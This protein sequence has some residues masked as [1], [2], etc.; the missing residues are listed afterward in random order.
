MDEKELLK[1]I[2]EAARELLQS[3]R[4]FDIVRLHLCM[5]IFVAVHI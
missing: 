2:D 1:I 4:D 3:R 5:R